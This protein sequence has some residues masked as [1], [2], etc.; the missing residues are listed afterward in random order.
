MRRPVRAH[1]SSEKHSE[2]SSV[3]G[4]T[5]TQVGLKLFYTAKHTSYRHEGHPWSMP[6]PEW[7]ALHIGRQQ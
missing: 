1:R 6:T 5:A 3:E 2:E 7:S 4:V